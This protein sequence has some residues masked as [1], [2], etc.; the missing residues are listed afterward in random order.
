MSAHQTFLSAPDLATLIYPALL[1]AGL[2]I[3]MSYLARPRSSTTP[4]SSSKTLRIVSHDRHAPLFPAPDLHYDLRR[5][6]NPAP[7]TRDTRTGHSAAV[8]D[9]LLREPRFRA[10]LRA[11]EEDIRRAM[12]RL[13]GDDGSSSG[14]SRRGNRGGGAMLRVGC[15]CGSGHHRSVAF[16]EQLAAIDWPE[17]WGLE[18]VHRDL[19]PDVERQKEKA[20]KKR[21]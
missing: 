3:A 5:V 19:T 12:R 10:L 4:R 8:R 15:L 11:A 6:R 2:V 13:D 9:E 1:S 7:A 21:G 14:G 20:R 18:V 17:D 16:A